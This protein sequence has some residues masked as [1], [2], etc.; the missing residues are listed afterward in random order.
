MQSENILATIMIFE[1]M[2]NRN[3]IE[4][5]KLSVEDTGSNRMKRKQKTN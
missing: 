5:E 4:I 3:L 1:W 2:K